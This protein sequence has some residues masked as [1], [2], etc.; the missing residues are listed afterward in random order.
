[1]KEFSK[2]NKSLFVRF[3]L[4]GSRKSG[5][6]AVRCLFS[7]LPRIAAFWI[8]SDC[9]L[10]CEGKTF[11]WWWGHWERLKLWKYWAALFSRILHESI[12]GETSALTAMEE[13]NER[14]KFL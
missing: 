10:A 3:V 12:S 5:S 9:F 1:M 7:C 14:P 4:K 6:G 11:I 8:A 13:V 2:L